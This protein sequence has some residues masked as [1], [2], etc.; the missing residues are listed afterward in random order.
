MNFGSAAGKTLLKLFIELTRIIRWQKTDVSFEISKYHQAYAPSRL[1]I[2][3]WVSDADADLFKRLFLYHLLH[4]VF[5]I[6]QSL[7]CAG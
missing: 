3:R 1:E 2:A 7:A 5:F 4:S 6:H